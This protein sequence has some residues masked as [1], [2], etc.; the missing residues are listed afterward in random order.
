M[1]PEVWLLAAESILNGIDCGCCDAISWGCVM[2]NIPLHQHENY[3]E[4]FR[5]Y[6]EPD[7]PHSVFWWYDDCTCNHPEGITPRVLA[8]LLMYEMEVNP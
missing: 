4:R 8:L 7:C 3:Q 1:N 6:F 5:A 2:E